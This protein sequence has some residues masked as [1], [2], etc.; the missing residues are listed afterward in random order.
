MLKDE[1]LLPR[2]RKAVTVSCHAIGHLTTDFL[3]CQA[4]RYFVNL[5]DEKTGGNWT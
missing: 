4:D 5:Y 1:I 2:L 3:P